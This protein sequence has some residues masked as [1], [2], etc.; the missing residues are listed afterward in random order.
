MSVVEVLDR[1]QGIPAPHMD[2]APVQLVP[3]EP[4]N[5]A[6]PIVPPVRL[7]DSLLAIYADALD[8]IERVRISNE[9]RVRALRQVKGMAG[10]PEA[11]RLDGLCGTL[12]ALEHGRVLEI[13]R[14]MRSHPLGPW[15]KSQCGI[16]DK[17][18]GRL[19]AA[20]GDPYWHRLLDRPRT[21]SELWA[22]CGLHVLHPDPSPTDAHTARVGVEPSG[23]TDPDRLD[24]HFSYVGAASPSSD[25]GAGVAAKRKKGQK[26]N[27]STVAKTRAVLIAG[28]CI[29]QAKSPYRAVYLERRVHT[30]ETHPKWEPIHSHNDGLRVTAKAVLRDLWTES[31]RLHEA[32]A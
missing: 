7:A 31:R 10:S 24:P 18:L 15:A 8:D 32:K 17:Q 19:L 29:K 25:P 22:F 4:R 28:S 2:S 11:D 12:L 9:N 1:G 14:A 30:A 27:W 5:P 21:V 26:A 20:I 16:G 3:T 13:Q 6:I 23:S